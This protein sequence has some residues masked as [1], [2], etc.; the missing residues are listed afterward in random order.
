MIDDVPKALRRARDRAR[1]A[2]VELQL[3]EGDV[4][5]LRATGVGSG[6]TFLLDFGMFDDELTDDQRAA[7]AERSPRSPRPAPRC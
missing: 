2:A 4:T 5:K 6:Y 1:E 7:W 3:I